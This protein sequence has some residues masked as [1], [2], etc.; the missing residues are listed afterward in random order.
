MQRRKLLMKK[1]ALTLGIMMFALAMSL[2]ATAKPA[3]PQHVQYFLDAA[4]A[5]WFAS[6]P[7]SETSTYISVNDT[8]TDPRLYLSQFVANYDADGNYTGGSSLEVQVVTANITLTLNTRSTLEAAH[9]S[10]SALP[11]QECTY[12]ADHNSTCSDVTVDVQVDWIGYGNLGRV[13]STY[14]S[15]SNGASIITHSE[16]F[17]RAATAVGTIDGAAIPGEGSGQIRSNKIDQT[18]K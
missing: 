10:G 18:T 2:Q 9:A 1:S 7:T 11:A 13:R 8:E 12:D 15:K 16:E 4:S 17:F 3:G 14:M 5:D 6:S